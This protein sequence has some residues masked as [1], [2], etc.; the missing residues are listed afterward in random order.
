MI[1][2]ASGVRFDSGSVFSRAQVQKRRD[3]EVTDAVIE[4]TDS[5]FFF[6]FGCFPSLAG[7]AHRRSRRVFQRFEADDHQGANGC[8]CVLH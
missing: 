2:T 8:L 5:I 1:D 7:H 4:T 6:P 3:K